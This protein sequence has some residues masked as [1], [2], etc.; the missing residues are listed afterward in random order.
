M[1]IQKTTTTGLRL[2]GMALVGLINV[3]SSTV[4]ADDAVILASCKDDLQL[5]DSGCACVLDKVHSELSENQLTF[6]VAAISEDQET[7]AQASMALTGA[8]MMEMATFMTST[9]QQCQDQ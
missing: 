7:M 5:S 2:A 1:I 8:E 9:P 6:F 3:G 4:T